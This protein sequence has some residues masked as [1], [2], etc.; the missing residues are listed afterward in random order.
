M[1]DEYGRAAAA[2][3]QQ[4]AALHDICVP[5]F[6]PL[7]TDPRTDDFNEAVENIVNNLNRNPSAGVS[8]AI[9]GVVFVGA[10]TAAQRFVVQ[11]NGLSTSVEVSS[12]CVVVVV[13]VRSC[14]S[15]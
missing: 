4:E 15:S 7:P 2:A 9:S 14:V 13:V 12:H 11:L 3:L 6:A 10:K 1:D 8:S 5:V